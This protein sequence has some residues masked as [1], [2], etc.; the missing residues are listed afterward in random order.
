MFLWQ[1]VD[2]GDELLDIFVQKQRETRAALNLLKLV[3]RSPPVGSVSI[4]MDVLASCSSAIRTIGG[5][6][7]RRSGRLREK[8]GAEVSQL[9]IR[10]RERKR[11][12]F[13]SQTSASRFLTPHAAICNAFDLQLHL[14]S[15]RSLESNRAY[16]MKFWLWQ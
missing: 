1:A 3:L 7:I 2:H 12:G 4:A 10:R 11:L 15:R 6:E 16:C 5:E 8:G 9:P 14:I 13:E